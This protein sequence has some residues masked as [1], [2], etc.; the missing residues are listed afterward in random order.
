ML[1]LHTFELELETF[2]SFGAR[3]RRVHRVLRE[4]GAIDVPRRVY[5]STMGP[6]GPA[7]CKR[8]LEVAPSLAPCAQGSPVTV[9]SSFDERVGAGTP[10]CTPDLEELV[11]IAD[12]VPARFALE[13]ACFF[14]GPVPALA[15]TGA[16]PPP[17]ARGSAFDVAAAEIAVVEA[18]VKRGRDAFVRVGAIGEA[19]QQ[20]LPAATQALIDALGAVKR[21]T[22]TTA[23]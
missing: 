17:R 21:H 11:A 7:I 3:L 6:R 8:M 12:G 19:P 15:L 1:L 9:L 20:P 2:E 16:S 14:Y 22:V 4:A 5:L 10:V 23:A 18:R 13:Q